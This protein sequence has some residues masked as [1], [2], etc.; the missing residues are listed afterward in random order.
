MQELGLNID[1]SGAIQAA[2]ALERLAQAAKEAEAAI[3]K[4]NDQA[5]GGLVFK[6]V[7][8]VCECKVLP[9]SN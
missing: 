8:D 1:A 2:E 7:G 6:M 4:L 9:T 3:A 5:H